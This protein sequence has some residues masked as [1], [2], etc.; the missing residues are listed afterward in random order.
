MERL[1]QRIRNHS[2]S[3]SKMASSSLTA[4]I[5]APTAMPVPHKPTENFPPRCCRNESR[6]MLVS[7]FHILYA[8]G[9]RAYSRLD[10][11]TN[12]F[13]LDRYLGSD[14]YVILHVRHARCSPRGAF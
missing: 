1:I 4:Q 13:V 14:P 12:I 7:R 8:R 3:M 9:P 2:H 11:C 6:S 10:K 5:C